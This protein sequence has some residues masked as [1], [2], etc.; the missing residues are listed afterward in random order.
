MLF[1]KNQTARK[2]VSIWEMQR[3]IEAIDVK[4]S[5]CLQHRGEVAGG[6]YSWDSED[7]RKEYLALRKK[8]KLLVDKIASVSIE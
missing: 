5:E 3:V 4:A 2:P 6:E 8:R 1:D 7:H